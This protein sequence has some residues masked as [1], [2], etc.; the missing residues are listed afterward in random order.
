MTIERPMFPP[1]AD[2]VHA[3]PAQP[4]TGQPE[5]ATRTSESAKATGGLSRRPTK[6]TKEEI[7]LARRLLAERQPDSVFRRL[8][9]RS[10]GHARIAILYRPELLNHDR[11]AIGAT[12][13]LE[14]RVKVPPHVREDAN[15]R[16][17]AP[18]TL[19]AWICGD[20]APGQSALD[21]RLTSVQA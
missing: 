4:A 17:G 16:A 9:G 7:E 2:S 14:L 13:E 8:L 19:L 5:S 6:W 18:R 20:P 12:I 3:F 10:K 11:R 15:R 1:R 21:K